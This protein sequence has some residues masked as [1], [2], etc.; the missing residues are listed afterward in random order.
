MQELQRD[1]DL[2]EE[3]AAAGSSSITALA[4]ATAASI[5][6]RREQSKGD[7][8]RSCGAQRGLAGYLGC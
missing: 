7:L 8:H 6:Q 3:A 5:E 2:D 4:A 1:L